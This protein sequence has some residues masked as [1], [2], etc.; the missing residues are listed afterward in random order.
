MGL[1]CVGE[2]VH[3]SIR[4]KYRDLQVVQSKNSSYPNEDR[5]TFLNTI[6]GFARRADWLDISKTNREQNSSN[7]YFPADAL[8]AK[9]AQD[10]DGNGVSDNFDRVA[11]YNLFHPKAA[12]DQELTPKDPGVAADA[13]DGRALNGAVDL[14]WRLA[15]YN[16]WT[17]ELKGQVVLGDGYY[18]GT[19][20]D[21]LF[22]K[23]PAKEDGQDIIRLEVNKCYAH[24]SESLLGAC[25][26]YETGFEEGMKNGLSQ[27]DAELSGMLMAAKFLEV[28]SA[29]TNAQGAWQAML[30]F[31][32]LPATRSY[33]DALASANLDHDMAAGTPETL[34]DLKQKWHV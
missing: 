28:D 7:Y 9:R 24:T 31:E 17:Q 27:P 23:T 12:F 2:G 10:E 21:P 16:S 14:L 26:H 33:G 8:I 22:R 5:A 32:G 11:H 25:L 29:T 30:K 1:Q 4:A 3:L 20:K 19:P 34:A 15:A 13:L 18:E 6:L